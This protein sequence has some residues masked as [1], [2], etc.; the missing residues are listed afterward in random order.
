M[1]SS[2]LLLGP[3]KPPKLQI[4]LSPSESFHSSF[5]QDRNK[6]FPLNHLTT[7]TCQHKQYTQSTGRGGKAMGMAD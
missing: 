1:R 7:P 3:L 6:A 2:F 5:T 4:A